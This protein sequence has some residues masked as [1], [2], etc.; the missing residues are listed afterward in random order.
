M[1]FNHRGLFPGFG[2][3]GFVKIPAF[4]E[5]AGQKRVLLDFETGLH[6]AASNKDHCFILY[7]S[8]SSPQSG[9]NKHK[10]VQRQAV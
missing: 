9:L 4:S 1:G 3:G 2:K 8:L 7:S 6:M 10:A 5:L